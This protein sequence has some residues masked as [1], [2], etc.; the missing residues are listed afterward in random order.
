MVFLLEEVDGFLQKVMPQ[1]LL[2]RADNVLDMGVLVIV[3]KVISILNS[4]QPISDFILLL[5]P[6][7]FMVG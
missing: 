7:S 4:N 1:E 6:N 5:E 3:L 2:I